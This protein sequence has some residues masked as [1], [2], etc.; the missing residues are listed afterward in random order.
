[1]SF[2]SRKHS[3]VTMALAL[4]IPDSGYASSDWTRKFGLN[5]SCLEDV[6]PKAGSR[7]KELRTPIEDSFPTERGSSPKGP[8]WRIWDLTFQMIRQTPHDYSV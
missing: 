4:G 7:T 8:I 3:I 2:S 5:R 6:N 1:M